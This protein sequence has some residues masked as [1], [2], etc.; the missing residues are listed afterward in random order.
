MLDDASLSQRSA[1]KWLDV[2][3]RTMRKYLAGHSPI[4][5][6]AEYALRWAIEE[7]KRR[8]LA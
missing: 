8:A 2:N 1:A 5:R 7:M 3:E 6:M 4:P